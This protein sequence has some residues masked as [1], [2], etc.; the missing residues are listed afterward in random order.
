MN[1]CARY[2][3][4]QLYRLYLPA[5][6][7]VIIPR[8]K[9]GL[10]IISMSDLNII[11]CS[12]NSLFKH[13]VY[14]KKVFLAA[15]VMATLVSGS[16]MAESITING[17]MIEE[18]C[19]FGNNGKA[20]ITLNKLASKDVQAAPLGSE[21]L[22]QADSFKISNCPTYDVRLEFK[23]QAPDGYPGA[24]VNTD[25]NGEYIAHFLRDGRDS[26]YKSLTDPDSNRVYLA[27][28]AAAAAQ[29]PEGYQSPVLAGYTKIKEVGS[30]V[31]IAGPTSSTID[32]SITYV[33]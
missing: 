6:I 30:G 8:A 13:G 26:E 7:N 14:M 29:S 5:M 3:N 18:G 11:L 22:N 12:N 10:L 20:D 25:V 31:S 27:K 19:K 23:A 16:A 17:D 21:L 33:Q 28:A 24:I 32:L 15:A 2:A 9:N 1:N 4:V